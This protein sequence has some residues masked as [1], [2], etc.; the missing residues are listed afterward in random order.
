AQP[1]QQLVIDRVRGFAPLLLL[2]GRIPQGRI[3]PGR[4][5]LRLPRR[6]LGPK[7]VAVALEGFK[8]DAL[9]LDR[10]EAPVA[11]QA[12]EIARGLGRVHRAEE[13]ALAV[14]FGRHAVV[15]EPGAVAA[16]R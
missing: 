12:G 1:R 9:Y 10:P 4:L 5:A 13:H 11:G 14:D 7:L 6:R 3:E 16:A 15:G 8:V 2:D